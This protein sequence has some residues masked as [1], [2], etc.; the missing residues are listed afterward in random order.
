MNIVQ[1]QKT[2]NSSPKS[3][4]AINQFIE[5]IVLLNSKNLPANSIE[6]INYQVQ[7][8]NVSE[9]TGNSFLHLLKKKQ[10][11][12]LKFI[13]KEV[14]LVPKNY[15]R[16]LWL[17]LGLSAFGIPLG[18]AI[19]LSAKNMGLLGIGLPI[20]ILIGMALGISL[21]KKAKEKGNQLDIELK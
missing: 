14:K 7:E 15:Y 5:L 11:K 1:L 9:L 21:D 12:I 3:T 13:E 4:H 10:A 19:G 17:A 20:G 18:V 16:N 6:M 2:D 8:L